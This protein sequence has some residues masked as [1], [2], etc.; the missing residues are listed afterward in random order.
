MFA[1]KMVPSCCCNSFKQSPEESPRLSILHGKM[2]TKELVTVNATA[3]RGIVL[4]NE[5]DV[6]QR[7][8][9]VDESARMTARAVSNQSGR[10][11]LRISETHLNK[12]ALEIRALRYSVSVR[13]FSK[14]FNMRETS[15][16]T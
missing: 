9:R 11:R 1:M 12:K 3:D 6:E 7:V 2:F 14:A 4:L 16:Y 13:W 8:V 5:G 10:H 15:E